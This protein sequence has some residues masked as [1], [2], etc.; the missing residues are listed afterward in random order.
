MKYSVQS[1]QVSLFILLMTLLSACVPVIEKPPQ[2]DFFRPVDRVVHKKEGSDSLALSEKIDSA[3]T[4]DSFKDSLIVLYQQQN[5]RLNDLTQQL[6]LVTKKT[7]TGKSAYIDASNDIL[8]HRMTVSNELLLEKI[9]DQNKHLN[10]VIEQLK[11]ISQNQQTQSGTPS[12]QPEAAV[13]PPNPAPAQQIPVLITDANTVPRKQSSPQKNTPPRPA[14]SS[15]TYAKAIDLYK[16]QQYGKAIDLFVKL[17]NQKIEPKL[18]DRYRFWMGVCYLNLNNSNQ[19]IK[20]FTH[21]LEYSHSEKA[22]EAYFMLGQ[23]YERTGEKISARMIYE[24][25]LRLYP[26]GNLKQVAEKKLAL[27]K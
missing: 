5:K 19:A 26:Q 21:V 7:S 12:L 16:S 6:N 13:I 4:E 27:L 1:L 24:K 11:L 10:D 9:K 23:C 14:N 25:L 8:A 15:L 22:E 20:E 18:A 17:L 2:N 3:Y